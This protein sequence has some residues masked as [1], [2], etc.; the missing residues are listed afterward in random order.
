[1]L[2]FRRMRCRK[3]LLAVMLATSVGTRE[4]SGASPAPLCHLYDAHDC[5]TRRREDPRRPQAAYVKRCCPR[6]SLLLLNQTCGAGHTTAADVAV[7]R[8]AR[9]EG[10]WEE[11]PLLLTCREQEGSS[12]VRRTLNL[13]TVLSADH[14]NVVQLET[15]AG[16]VSLDYCV[17]VVGGGGGGA[18]LEAPVEEPQDQ[19]TAAAPP[20]LT[21]AVHEAQTGP[22]RRAPYH[23]VALFCATDPAVQRPLDR[24]LCRDTPCARKCCPLGKFLKYNDTNTGVCIYTRTA[25][26]DW[27]PQNSSFGRDVPSDMRMVFTIPRDRPCYVLHEFLLLGNGNLEIEGSFQMSL[28]DYCIDFEVS[29]GVEGRREAARICPDPKVCWWKNE[30]QDVI[31]LSVSCVFLLLTVVAYVGTPALRGTNSSRCLVALVVSRLLASLIN[32]TTNLTRAFLSSETHL[33]SMAGESP[34]LRGHA[35]GSLTL[36]SSP[37]G[38]PEPPMVSHM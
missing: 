1:M 8:V 12:L 11:Q 19:T 6:G 2:K 38:E 26:D 7:P 16:L 23:Y 29:Q 36:H 25:A 18:G 31:F 33:C 4:A 24:K 21:E 27:T 28:D 15:A 35:P 13:S 14:D 20:L 30:L 5:L 32:I 3:W 22:G 17:G 10:V 34:G 9:A 37:T